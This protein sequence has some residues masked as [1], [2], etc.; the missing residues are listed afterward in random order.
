MEVREKILRAAAVV[1]GETGYRGATTR[2]IAQE[3]GVNEI[4]LFRHFGSKESLIHEALR[5]TGIVDRR[6]ALPEIPRNPAR[7]LTDWSMSQFEFLYASRSLIRKCLGEMEE[8]PDSATYASSCPGEALHQ[9]RQYLEALHEHGFIR[10]PFDARIAAGFFLGSIFAEAITRDVMPRLYST[11]ARESMETRVEFLLR[12]V[13]A[14]VPAKAAVS[15]ARD[16]APGALSAAA[17]RAARS[18]AATDA[19]LSARGERH[20]KRS[21]G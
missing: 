3:A 5:C 4:T 9:L 15:K 14:V 11:T 21:H 18:A 16:E 8:R 10:G 7:E 1:Y 17:R 20:L 13:N 12:A 6:A 2:R 19:R